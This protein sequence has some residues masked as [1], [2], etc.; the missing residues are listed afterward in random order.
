MPSRHSA[1][2]SSTLSGRQRRSRRDLPDDG[3]A[4]GVHA[5][6][7][8]LG[9][10]GHRRSRP[11]VPPPIRVEYRAEGG[12]GSPRSRRV[13]SR[14]CCRPAAP[15]APR[16]VAVDGCRQPRRLVY[17]VPVVSSRMVLDRRRAED[18]VGH[19][20][21]AGRVPAHASPTPCRRARPA[22][23]GPRRKPVRDADGLVVAGPRRHVQDERRPQADLELRPRTFTA[24]R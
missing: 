20:Q 2:P 12:H 24:G 13:K 19:E 8:H 11:R 16:A 10:R 3:D 5:V 15:Q 14:P 23:P 22:R 21:L 17:V 4:R 1:S 7:A 18:A 6:A 9:G